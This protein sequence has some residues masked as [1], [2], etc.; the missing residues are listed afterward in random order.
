MYHSSLIITPDSC[1]YLVCG[2]LVDASSLEPFLEQDRQTFALPPNMYDY[3]G[4]YLRCYSRLQEFWWSHSMPIHAWF[5]RSRLLC[6][7]VTLISDF[8]LTILAWVSILSFMLV[9]TKGTWLSHCIVLFWCSHQRRILWSNCRW[10][11]GP[12][13]RNKGIASLEMDVHNRRSD[14]HLYR[15]YRVL[16]PTKLPAIYDLVD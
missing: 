9:Y 6:K 1:Q 11:H 2:L 16:Y 3:L 13:G 14:Y 12:Y 7:S 5:C 4:G 15:F 10:H 8:Q